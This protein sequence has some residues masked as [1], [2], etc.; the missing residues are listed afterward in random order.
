MLLSLFLAVLDDAADT[1]ARRAASHEVARRLGI[2]W[3][4]VRGEPARVE[5]P[6]PPSFVSSVRIARTIVRQVQA[7]DPGDKELQTRR[8]DRALLRLQAMASAWLS[9]PTPF[10][11]FRVVERV[12]FLHAF[13]PGVL[14][15]K[16]DRDRLDLERIDALLLN[17]SVL[18]KG[19]YD[20]IFLALANALDAVPDDDWAQTSSLL[21]A[22]PISIR[23]W[24]TATHP[25]ITGQTWND[26]VAQAEAWHRR[27]RTQIGYGKPVAD[28]LVVLRWPDGVTLQRLVTKRDFAAEGASMGHCVGG[29]QDEHRLPNGDS[30]YYRK[31]RDGT[32]ATYSLRAP[33]GIPAATF[34][35]VFHRV[36]SPKEM[37]TWRYAEVTQIQGPE[38]DEISSFDGPGLD[39][40]PFKQDPLPYLIRALVRLRLLRDTV[41]SGAGEF[42]RLS[43]DALERLDNLT[44]DLDAATG[45]VWFPDLSPPV[46]ARALAAHETTWELP[47]LD[48]EGVF[49]A[50]VALA[51]MPDVKRLFDGK[52]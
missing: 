31:S 22:D 32:G 8:L 10:S 24:F 41:S 43:V 27:M 12:P 42:G 28:A 45:P 3:R 52:G 51:P 29:D 48:F 36:F 38:D 44:T 4:P 50:R 37:P 30:G 23:D 21:T 26:L 46:R 25:V 34:E 13:T 18:K 40:K 7:M 16:D 19:P 35:V 17:H 15:E 47:V 11:T 6:A 9:T 39:G 5:P 14:F 49:W 20:G 33:S 1:G 2:G